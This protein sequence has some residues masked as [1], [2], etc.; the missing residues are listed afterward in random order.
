MMQSI[1]SDKAWL[2]QYCPQATPAQIYQFIE[3]VG[4]K[5]DDAN[6]PADVLQQARSEAFKELGY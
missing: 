5:V 2:R 4:M 6:P 3:R 1:R